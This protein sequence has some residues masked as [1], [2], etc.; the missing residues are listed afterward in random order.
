MAEQ[1]VSWIEHFR[2]L[3]KVQSRYNYSI[4]A[5]NK[6]SFIL[7]GATKE[8]LTPHTAEPTPRQEILRRAFTVFSP[9]THS[10][11]FLTR[12]NGHVAV[13]INIDLENFDIGTLPKDNG[14]DEVIYQHYQSLGLNSELFII[15]KAIKLNEWSDTIT[16][17]EVE[18]DFNLS[19]PEIAVVE[20]VEAKVKRA[21]ASR[22]KV[23]APP[24]IIPE[25]QKSNTIDYNVN[26][27]SIEDL[28]ALAISIVYSHYLLM[29]V[30]ATL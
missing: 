25:V 28:E 30:E 7:A 2:N 10:R 24:V 18:C 9:N 5:D 20:P 13:V 11:V 29:Q 3:I 15:L 26:L 16:V 14:I 23:V 21:R 8:S 22:K 12:A 4:S 19:I 6:L 27:G 1:T 17:T